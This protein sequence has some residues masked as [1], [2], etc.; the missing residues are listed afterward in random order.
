MN[1]LWWRQ[2]QSGYDT[3]PVPYDHTLA[4]ITTWQHEVDVFQFLR[5]GFSERCRMSGENDLQLPLRPAETP[6]IHQESITPSN[7]CLETILLVEDHEAIRR[8]M[9]RCLLKQGY[10]VLSAASGPEAIQVFQ[11][12]S[13]PIQLLISDV[14]MPEM[15]GTQLAD[16][17]RL[18][19]PRMK[20]LYISGYVDDWNHYFNRAHG[21]QYFF[22]KPFQIQEFL[23]AVRTSLNRNS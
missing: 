16:K 4:T 19:A 20:V 7:G 14:V 22:Q 3:V 10:K 15:D 2:R 12:S 5:S 17:L 1:C 8:M 6:E 21:D 9:V 18:L 11:S 13:E 23:A